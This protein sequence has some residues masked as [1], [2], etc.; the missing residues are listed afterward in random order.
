MRIQR[1]RYFRRWWDQVER[2]IQRKGI[3]SAFRRECHCIRSW[4]SMNPD[5]ASR[6]YTTKQGCIHDTSPRRGIW[7]SNFRHSGKKF[8]FSRYVFS[9]F[10]TISSRLVPIPGD[11]FLKSVPAKFL[12]IHK[13]MGE[14]LIIS[15]SL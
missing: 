1:A 10:Q 8:S 3:V 7:G 6:P 9:A 11:F 14:Y 12:R 5:N 2:H 13:D 4:S 15:W